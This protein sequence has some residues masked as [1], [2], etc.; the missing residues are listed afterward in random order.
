MKFDG[1]T[2]TEVVAKL[3][4]YYH[5]KHNLDIRT[6][7]EKAM[8]RF[9]GTWGLVVMCSDL[10]EEL[11]VT[12]H[13]SPLYIGVGDEGTFVAS[14]P[15]AFKDRARSYIKLN[16]REVATITADGRNLDLTKLISAKDDDEEKASPAPYP[17]WYIKE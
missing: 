2:D 11:I 1:A 4:G 9:E 6:A 10:P 3:I 12:S 7:T 15:S 16:D 8:K 13:G 17:H 14:N 5:D